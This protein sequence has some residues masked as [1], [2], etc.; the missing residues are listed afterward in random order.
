MDI[1]KRAATLLVDTEQAMRVLLEEGVSRQSYR[2]VAEVARVAEGIAAIRLSIDGTAI[3]PLSGRENEPPAGA[4]N[5]G[6][7][8]EIPPGSP[9]PPKAHTRAATRATTG[10]AKPKE[11]SPAHPVSVKYPYFQSEGD[12][13]L[14]IGWSERDGRSYEHRAPRAVVFRTCEAIS[15]HGDNGR[16][17]K[18]EAIVQE[19]SQGNSPIPSYQAYLALAWL[20]D[21]DVVEKDGKEGYRIKN[22]PLT[23]DRLTQLWN[24]LTPRG[25]D[26][27]MAQ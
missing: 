20:R 23:P 8:A 16:Q 13:L 1:L 17:F 22:S 15:R 6:V 14:K 4:H 12:R 21:A 10:M 3:V 5:I 27:R 7:P 9:T 19:L 25:G 26:R 24:D 2:Q 11:I 18:M